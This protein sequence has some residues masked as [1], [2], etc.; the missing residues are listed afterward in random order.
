MAWGCCG[1]W[2]GEGFPVVVGRDLHPQ[3]PLTAKCKHRAPNPALGWVRGATRQLWGGHTEPQGLSEE[4]SLALFGWVAAGQDPEFSLEWLAE[5]LVGCVTC[6]RLLSLA[7]A[8]LQPWARAEGP[9]GQG[10]PAA[11]AFQT[12]TLLSVT[13]ATVAAGTSGATPEA[14]RAHPQGWLQE[15][16][17]RPHSHLC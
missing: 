17:G 4:A 14:A 1:V 8:L 11:N 7:T 13:C 2:G 12:Q 10:I 15:S 3:G 16:P 5:L 9:N 6:S